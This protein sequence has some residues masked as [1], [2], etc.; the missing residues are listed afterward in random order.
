M[1]NTNKSGFRW[2]RSGI[3]LAAVIVLLAGA[4]G[5]TWAFLVAQSEPVQNN[6][7]YAHVR[8]TIDEKFDGTTKSN[9]KIQNTG[10][11]PAYIRARIV[12][13]WKDES[14]N[15]SAVPVDIMDYSI[16]FNRTDWV[17]D[18]NNTDYWYCKKAVDAKG[19]TPV[20]ITDCTK[21]EIAKVPKGYD[22][23]VE[24]LADAIQSTPASAVTEAWNVT[25]DANGNIQ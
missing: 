19:F 12:V 4:V 1:R 11:I 3:L 2:K 25:V 6:F 5:G 18:E 17:Q 14:G 7:T 9:V 15:V 10:D 13:T 20:L 22:L 24:I 21:T 23:S 16:H 8:C